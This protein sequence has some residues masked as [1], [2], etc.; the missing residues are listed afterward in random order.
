MGVDVVPLLVLVIPQPVHFAD[1]LSRRVKLYL[2]VVLWHS[3]VVVE[4]A[5]RPVVDRLRYR[6]PDVDDADAVSLRMIQVLLAFFFGQ[7]PPETPHGSSRC[8]VDV[9][10]ERGRV[11]GGPVV[12]ERQVFEDLVEVAVA[13]VVH[14]FPELVVKCKN[15]LGVEGLLH[16]N[17]N[18]VDVCQDLRLVGVDAE[19]TVIRI[20][21]PLYS[22]LIEVEE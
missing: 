3:R 4:D 19:G 17:V 7:V 2:Y 5:Q 10:H 12:C 8:C 16:R 9:C 6:P 11:R 22:M 13:H 14:V 1:V 21:K 15:K 18:A 20:G